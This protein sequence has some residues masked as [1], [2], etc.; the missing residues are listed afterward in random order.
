MVMIRRMRR[1]SRE[2]EDYEGQESVLKLFTQAE[3][4]DLLHDLDL[5]KEYVQPLG[6]RLKEK[7]LLVP[8]IKFAFYRY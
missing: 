6:S 5:S 2:N 4:N 1:S 7:S 3:L 8:G